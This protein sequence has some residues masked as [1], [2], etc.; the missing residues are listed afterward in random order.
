MDQQKKKC[1]V[2]LKAQKK[3]IKAELCNLDGLPCQCSER[4]RE[5]SQTLFYEHPK[6]QI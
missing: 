4:L 3:F 5:F 6:M 2:N 1:K